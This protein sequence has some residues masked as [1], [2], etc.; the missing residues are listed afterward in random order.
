MAAFTSKAAGNWSASGQTTWNEVG[1]PGSGDTVTITHAITVD[2]TTTV[3]DQPGTDTVVLSVSGVDLTVADGVTF[4]IRGGA[5]FNNG[6][7]IVG[8]G[9]T[10][11]YDVPSG[12]TY[13]V[14]LGTAGSQARIPRLVVNGT[15]G[16]R[17]YY[18][19]KAGGGVAHHPN[20]SSL[21]RV[22]CV[23]ATYCTFT[24]IGNSS[25]PAF[26]PGLNGSNDVLRLT[27]VILDAC[28]AINHPIGIAAGGIVDFQQVTWKNTAASTTY[29]NNGSTTPTNTRR[30]KNVV[31]DK[32]GQW[33]LGGYTYDNVVWYGTPTFLAGA[34][35][36][37]G[38]WQNCLIRSTNAGGS[39]VAFA[40]RGTFLDTYLL[41]DHSNA[42]PHGAQLGAG[43]GDQVID[44]WL[45]EYTGTS[46][47]GDCFTA[48]APASARLVTLKRCLI[49]PN[50]S[51]GQSGTLLSCLA[52]ANFS[53]ILE[54]NTA[55]VTAANSGLVVGETYAGY[56]GM[57]QS[58]KSNLMWRAT[59]G[60][61]WKIF[62]D[63]AG[64]GTADICAPGNA[65]YNAGWN[66][67][68]GTD[69]K[70][71]QASSGTM[72]STAPGTHDL[73]DQDPQFV[74]ASRDLASWDAALGG[75]GT[76]ANALA[77]LMKLNDTG[78]NSAYTVAA[79]L[80]WVRAG[81]APRNTALQGA[82]HDAGTIGAV[83]AAPALPDPFVTVQFRAA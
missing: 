22:S 77:E 3:G 81:F 48:A 38:L 42:N 33:P 25:L 8:A 57:I 5:S 37:V 75:A 20:G 35:V 51:G 83:A 71:Y 69:G 44:G 36:D 68:A 82:A 31:F 9:C 79:L 70:G 12:Q 29:T 61:G 40:G 17:S 73:A 54:H 14:L 26:R 65:D 64:T 62:R 24:R 59:A 52:G 58:F 46:T 7:F 60:T 63:A 80:A 6:K 28:G 1:V 13:S 4:T 19:S 18:Q 53:A 43:S 16:A 23:D 34:N 50:S 21:A 32:G 2:V 47:T 66:L 30:F 78:Y 49:L 11:E 56:A 55:I 15:S 27:N 45:V 74:D 41:E 72:F 10:V 76:V 39:A 67:G